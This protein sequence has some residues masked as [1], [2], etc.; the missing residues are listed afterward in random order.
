MWIGKWENLRV[1]GRNT[2]QP[3]H[4]D[5]A[6]A[7]A[8]RR[9]LTERNVICYFP[10]KQTVPPERG[11]S[12]WNKTINRRP[13][14]ERI[15]RFAFQRNSLF[16]ELHNTSFSAPKEPPCFLSAKIRNTKVLR[17]WGDETQHLL[18]K[19]GSLKPEI[20]SFRNVFREPVQTS[21]FTCSAPQKAAR[22]L[23]VAG[24]NF[25]IAIDNRVAVRKVPRLNMTNIFAYEGFN[26]LNC[27]GG[28]WTT[29]RA[30]YPVKLV[31]FARPRNSFVIHSV[32]SG[33]GAQIELCEA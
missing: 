9:L 23:P 12:L 3:P 6:I 10:Y 1:G 5:I 17:L 7:Y 13:L 26:P 4:P 15:L 29:A 16:I 18:N 14:K 11:A 19:R 8:W 24:D 2:E 20:K 33:R 22:S 27:T 32:W 28:I 30:S 21:H 25:W 31:P